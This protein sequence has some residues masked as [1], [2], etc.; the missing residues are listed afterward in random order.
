LF[1]EP[2]GKTTQK[3]GQGALFKNNN[4]QKALIE[5]GEA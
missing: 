1:G 2:Q 4:T 5:R 3:I